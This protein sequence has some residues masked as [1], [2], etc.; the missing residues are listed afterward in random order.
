MNRWT[1]EKIN[2]WWDQQPWLMGANYVPSDAVNNIE[3]WRRETFNP[4]L[5]R[6]ELGWAADVG[7]NTLRVFLS[8][9]V[10]AHEGQQFLDTFEEFLQIA[11][12]CGHKVLPILFDDCA[13]DG[14]ADPVYGPQPDPIPG[15]H[16]SRWVP[17][18]GQAIQDDPAQTAACKAYLDAVIGAHRTDERIIAWDLFNE[19]GNTNRKIN[20]LPLVIHAFQWAR[21]LN[22]AQPLTSGMW[23]FPDD[24]L[25]MNSII[26]GLSDV[27]S[28]HTYRNHEKTRALVEAAK[29]NSGR[30]VWITEWLFR[31]RGDTIFENLPYFKEQKV[32]VWQ[33]GLVQGR[34][35]THLDW[36][37]WQIPNPSPDVWQHDLLYPDGTPYD[38]D[39]VALMRRLTGRK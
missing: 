38:P 14:G 17:S 16:N 15:V 27:I 32:G 7:M 1:I 19:P 2:S 26:A 29:A 23:T 28:L 10:W 36:S 12:E 31:P 5:I 18:P 13:F 25:P 21:A 6:Q 3:M 9:A 11:H 20:S 8:Y 33:W 34:T 22:P 37:T 24:L 30:P 4:S 39:E 35:Q